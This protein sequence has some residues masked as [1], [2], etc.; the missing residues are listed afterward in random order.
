[1]VHA[2][3]NNQQPA[4]ES[5]LKKLITVPYIKPNNTEVN[6]PCVICSEEFQDNNLVIYLSCDSRHVFHENCIKN[7]VKINA[8]CPICRHSIQ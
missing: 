5:A 3:P 7:W 2:R 8:I 1:M 4:S 6:D